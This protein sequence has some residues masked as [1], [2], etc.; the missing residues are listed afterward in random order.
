VLPPHE[1]LAAEDAHVRES[2]AYV[3]KERLLPET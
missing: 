1:Q 3:V 2:L